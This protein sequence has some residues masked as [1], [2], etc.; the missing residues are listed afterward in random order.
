MVVGRCHLALLTR[1][2]GHLPWSQDLPA[3]EKGNP[4]APNDFFRLTIQKKCDEQREG[5]SCH[6]CNRLKIKCLGWGP[7]RPDWMRVRGHLD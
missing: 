2:D 1:L 4:L 5:D 6:T 7:K 3:T